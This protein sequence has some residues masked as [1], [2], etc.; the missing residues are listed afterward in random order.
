[1]QAEKVGDSSDSESDGGSTS[2]SEDEGGEGDGQE[3]AACR[4]TRTVSAKAKAAALEV[5]QGMLS[6]TDCLSTASS[7]GIY[8]EGVSNMYRA[9]SKARQSLLRF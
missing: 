9:Q 6:A 5:M 8:R 4:P 7:K 2:A 3:A 1:M